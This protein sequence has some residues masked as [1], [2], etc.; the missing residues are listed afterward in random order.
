MQQYVE[1]ALLHAYENRKLA[2]CDVTGAYLH[3]DMDDFIVVKIQGQIVNVLCAKNPSYEDFVVMENGKKTLYMQ[4]LKALY[5]SIKS[6]LLWNDIFTGTLVE[7][8]FELNP[9]DNC[10]ANKMINGK[11]CTIIW[12]V[13]DNCISHVPD[14]VLDMVIGKIEA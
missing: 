3:A 14:S 2:T 12:W 5:G 8:G 4:L 13:D 1:L 9:Y 7:M 10:V 6:A 11:Q